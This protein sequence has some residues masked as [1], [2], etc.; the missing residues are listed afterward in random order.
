MIK[1]NEIIINIDTYQ[2]FSRSESKKVLKELKK[3][4]DNNYIIVNKVEP[5]SRAL[6]K[7][8]LYNDFVGIPLTKEVKIIIERITKRYNKL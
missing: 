6:L 5:N 3:L 1:K 4:N 2:L 7:E 8:I